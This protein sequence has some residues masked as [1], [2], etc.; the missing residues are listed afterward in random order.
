MVVN[1]PIWATT[2]GDDTR[3]NR[4]TNISN[5]GAVLAT[6]DKTKFGLFLCTLDGSGLLKDHVYLCNT[7]GDALID[8]S[9]TGTHSHTGS[10]D[11][12]FLNDLFRLN[13]KHMELSLTRTH[14]L[15]QAQWITALTSGGTIEDNIDGTTG[16][17]SIRLRTNT[18]LGGAATIVYPHLKLDWS[19]LAFFQ[20]KIRLENAASLALHSGIACDHIT[21]SD[22]NN[23]KL[24]AEVC[25]V[26]NQNWWLRTADGTTNSAS[27][28]GIAIT[29]SR[30]GIRIKHLLSSANLLI[31]TGTELEKTSNLPTSG[32]TNDDNLIKHSIK[33][34]AAADKPMHVYGSRVVYT[35][36]DT[37]V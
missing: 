22:T 26:T 23:R 31:G 11:G 37:W 25:T 30:T 12:G 3:L 27:D 6:L 19:G 4:M 13:P 34:N 7:A 18:T 5:T 8:I 10:A 2:V 32:T 21:A 29:T 16:E 33:N 36:S 20:A 35:V 9:V 17:R 24:Q 15:K 28:T 14:D 1:T